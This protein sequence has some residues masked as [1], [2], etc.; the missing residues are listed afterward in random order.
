MISITFFGFSYPGEPIWSKVAGLDGK[1]IVQI[2]AGSEHSATVTGKISLSF[3]PSIIELLHIQLKDNLFVSNS[4]D[5]QVC[6]WGWGEH[7]QL[8]LGDTSDQSLP[9]V[10]DLGN[11]PG[12][13]LLTTRV[14]CGS[15][16]TIAVKMSAPSN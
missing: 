12:S 9:R 16:F 5:G 2:A 8:G 6:T 7:G 11:K 10:V 15:G 4:D 14:Y 1:R 3:Y 13:N